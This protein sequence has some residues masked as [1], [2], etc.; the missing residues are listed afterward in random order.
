MVATPK[1]TCSSEVRA[2]K[3]ASTQSFTLESASTKE[4]HYAE[5]LSFQK[6]A[7]LLAVANLGHLR[8]FK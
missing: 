1:L 7:D 6:P 3:C 5:R 8:G 2:P 4:A